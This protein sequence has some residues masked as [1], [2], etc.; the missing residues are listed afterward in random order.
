MA[1]ATTLEH[2]LGQVLRRP[3]PRA[4]ERPGNP[5]ARA[6]AQRLLSGSSIEIERLTGGGFNV[7]PPKDWRGTDPFEGDHYAN[8][9]IEALPMVRAYVAQDPSAWVG[10]RH[11]QREL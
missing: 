6:E 2:L 1:M 7:W 4:K 11:A 10:G 8:D 3:R 5:A 9:W